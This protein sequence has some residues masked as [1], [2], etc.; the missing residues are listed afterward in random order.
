[1]TDYREVFGET[2][3][4][5]APMSIERPHEHRWQPV[6]VVYVPGDEPGVTVPAVA[7][8]CECGAVQAVVIPGALR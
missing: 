4:A 1:M 3:P 7:Q 6:G 2:G 8:S 5:I